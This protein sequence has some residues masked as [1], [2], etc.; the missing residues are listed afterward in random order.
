MTMLTALPLL[1]YLS[2]ASAEGSF[3]LIVG[4]LGVAWSLAGAG[5]FV[6]LGWRQIGPRLALAG[7]RPWEML[8]GQFGMLAVFAVP[9]ILFFSTVILVGEDVATPADFVTAV[10]LTALVSIPL[11]LLLG[12]VAPGD[13][14]GTLGLIGILGIQMS[15]PASAGFASSMPLYGPITLV[16]SAYGNNIDVGAAVPHAVI[17][18]GLLTIAAVVFWSRRVRVAPLRFETRT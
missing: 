16:E 8:A 5:L 2:T 3:V 18:A 15:L 12:S 1:F 7:Y 17:S 11:G 9:L 13:L 4:G 10:A 14:E 6:G